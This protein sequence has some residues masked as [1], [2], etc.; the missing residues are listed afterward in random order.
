MS[1]N[2]LG[3]GGTDDA[4]L[5]AGSGWGLELNNV[6]LCVPVA[7]RLAAADTASFFCFVAERGY[8]FA[9]ARFISSVASSA[10]E[11][12]TIRR[13]TAAGTGIATAAVGSTVIAQT[14]AQLVN[15]TAGTAVTI[16][17]I[18]NLEAMAAGDKLAIVVSGTMTGLV[19][20]V[21][22]IYLQPI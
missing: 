5:N 6:D 20:A 8:K 7:V 2:V 14:T 17:P 3:I 11:T 13:H 9:G 12:V 1:Y 21:L 15:V 16:A 18:A 10:A 4:N 22:T 19:G